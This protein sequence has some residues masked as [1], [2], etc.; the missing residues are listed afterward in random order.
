VLHL[1]PAV[2]LMPANDE[3]LVMKLTDS[4]VRLD[5]QIS[6]ALERRPELKQSA[7]LSDAAKQNVRGAKYGP[8]IPTLGA[9]AFAGGLG[10]GESGSA[11]NFG[12]SQDYQVTLSWRIGTG[13]LFD[14]SRIHIAESKAAQA[15]IGQARTH[16]EVV[17]QVVENHERVK[18]LGAQL[19]IAKLSVKAAQEAH[20]L[21]VERK[22]FAVGVV[23]E[24]LQSEQDVTRAKLDYVN[25]VMEL[26]KAQYRLKAA[27]GR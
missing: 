10:G 16:D 7:A 17:R 26:N 23:L 27:V 15:V 14:T 2:N 22:E 13:G 9:Q 8:V 18:L 12:A 3:V 1:D 25:T 5:R 20:K 21:A 24:T 4:S 19:D 11:A 6:E